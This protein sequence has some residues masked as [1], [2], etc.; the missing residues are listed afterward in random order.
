[1]IWGQKILQQRPARNRSPFTPDSLT[2]PA[3]PCS[4][5]P[6]NS[7][8]RARSYNLT[9]PAPEANASKP[10]ISRRVDPLCIPKPAPFSHFIL[11]R[12]PRPPSTQLPAHPQ[13]TTHSREYIQST[14]K[15]H[16]EDPWC[17]ALLVLR[18]GLGYCGRS[19]GRVKS[20]HL[21]RLLG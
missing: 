13:K 8:D 10:G 3:F 12:P 7:S 21:L 2:R 4:N 19:E 20:N 1:M 16:T 15:F 17:Y 18:L 14:T 11:P 9:S 5:Q 6:D